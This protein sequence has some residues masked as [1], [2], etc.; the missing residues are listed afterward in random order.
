M[1]KMKNLLS[2]RYFLLIMV[3]CTISFYACKK[4]STTS[5]QSKVGHSELSR[6]LN[7]IS[8]S[9]S[10]LFRE[11]SSIKP[12]TNAVS[13]NEISQLAEDMIKVE[14]SMEKIEGTLKKVYSLNTSDME[15]LYTIIGRRNVEIAE[16]SGQDV[17]TEK[18]E[19]LIRE[20]L[21][22]KL[23]QKAINKYGKDIYRI[24]P[25]AQNELLHSEN[26]NAQSH[27]LIGCGPKESYPR[28][29]YGMSSAYYYDATDVSNTWN[30]WTDLASGCD[31]K[32]SFSQHGSAWY[33]TTA[34]IINGIFGAYKGVISAQDTP[35]NMI[36]GIKL[37][38]YY[39]ITSATLK[40]QLKLVR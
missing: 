10:D 12:Q 7:S 14:P 2:L 5:E 13:L 24:S 38:W 18:A 26:S 20:K 31:N 39:G 27:L 28:S 1:K 8:Y 16:A 32:T 19:L 36:T 23:N 11:L 29:L 6:T 37:W 34:N 15:K 4:S 9:Y 33:G 40:A 30:D 25:E 22:H 3:S 17:A 35:S 21:V